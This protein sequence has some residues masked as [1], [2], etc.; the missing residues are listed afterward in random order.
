MENLVK[1]GS[2]VP[3]TDKNRHPLLAPRSPQCSAPLP[4][5]GV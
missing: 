2:M 5:A 4:G 3:E 1:F